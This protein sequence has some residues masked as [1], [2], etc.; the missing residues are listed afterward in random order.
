MPQATKRKNIFAA[1]CVFVCAFSFIAFSNELT[2]TKYTIETDKLN[3]P[4]RIVFLAD[5]HSCIYG[6]NQE[7]LI[8]KIEEQKPDL[9]LMGGDIADDEM[10]HDGTIELIK[11]ISNKYDCYYVTGN[12]EF[13]SGEVGAIKN[14]LREY[15]V[16]VLEGERKIVEVKEQF[17]NICGVDDTA[18]GKAAF[19]K[20]LDNAF[21]SVD[22]NLFTIL[23]L[24]RPE[25]FEQVPRH[26]CDLILSG[27]AHGG[28]WRIPLLGGL[29]APNQGF[30]PKYTS[31]IYTVNETKMLV[32]RGL[33]RESTRIPRIFNPPE[34]VVIDIVFTNKPS[35]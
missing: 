6:K 14:F 2:V 30:F 26:S 20:Q 33:S 8:L 15:G 11:G 32:S 4:I 5:L 13:W 12:H 17:I 23:L 24:H 21:V 19:K 34:L 16:Y 28:Q 22:R 29:F 3:K 1:I 31:G 18:I 10:P 7:E 27:H 35:G 25:R 9:I